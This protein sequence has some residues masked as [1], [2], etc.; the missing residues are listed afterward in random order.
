VKAFK[1]AVHPERETVCMAPRGSAKKLMRPR[2]RIA[3]R[4][5]NDD[6]FAVYVE[7]HREDAGHIQP[8]AQDA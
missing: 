1:K 2:A 6:W 3:G 4:L 7:T 5:A 8:A